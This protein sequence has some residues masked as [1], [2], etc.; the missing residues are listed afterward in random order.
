[1][2]KFFFFL[3]LISSFILYTLTFFAHGDMY[4]IILIQLTQRSYCLTELLFDLVQV[5]NDVGR[6]N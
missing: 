1:M 4:Q 6:W 3:L 2:S 5:E